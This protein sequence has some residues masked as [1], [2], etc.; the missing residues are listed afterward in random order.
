[1]LEEIKPL[2]K[3][4]CVVFAVKLYILCLPRGF[5]SIILGRKSAADYP[6]VADL[7]D[8][9]FVDVDDVNAVIKI[10]LG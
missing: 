4:V 2:V 1:M 3:Y 9:G 10:I 6:G 8:S 7:D 5:I